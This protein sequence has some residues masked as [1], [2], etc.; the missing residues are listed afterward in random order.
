MLYSLFMIAVAE[1]VTYAL[2]LAISFLRL[3]FAELRREAAAGRGSG[4]AACL[5]ACSY[6]AV[7]VR[8]STRAIPNKQSYTQV[9]P[10]WKGR[11]SHTEMSLDCTPTRRQGRRQGEI[12]PVS[13]GG[14]PP[15]DPG[16][17]T[18]DKGRGRPDFPGSLSAPTGGS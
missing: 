3:Q 5:S 8:M 6:F 10:D 2:I 13:V 17:T 9:S 4:A 1:L 15:G 18:N 7:R 12:C 14:A 16:V 11:N